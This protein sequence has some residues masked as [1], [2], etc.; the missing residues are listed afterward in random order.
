V[1]NQLKIHIIKLI[2]I[3]W[4]KLLMLQVKLEFT[5]LLTSIKIYSLKNFVVMVYQSGS[6]INLMDIK[7]SHSQ[8][9]KKLN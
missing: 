9:V 1:Y 7:L 8:W 2:L 3:K 4:L 6:W 5:Q